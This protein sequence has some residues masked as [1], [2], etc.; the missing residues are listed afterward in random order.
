MPYITGSTSALVWR[1]GTE[2]VSIDAHRAL[3]RKVQEYACGCGVVGTVARS[4]T[5]NGT[6]RDI[7][8][9]PDAPSETWTVTFTDATNFTVSGSVTGSVAGGTVGTNYISDGTALTAKIAFRITAGGTA[10]VAADT[11]TIPVTA[12]A[13]SGQAEQWVLD[14]WS[15]FTTAGDGFNAIDDQTTNGATGALIFHGQGSGTEAIYQG[16]APFENAG[17][18]IWNWVH[19]AYSGFSSSASWDSQVNPSPE[20]FTAFIN[21][22]F[23][24][25]II[26]NERRIIVI[27]TASSTMHSCYMGFIKPFASP[28][29]WPYPN[30]VF[31]EEDAAT[32]YQNTGTNFTHS[33]FNPT[34]ANAHIRMVDGTWRPAASGT[35][36]TANFAAWPKQSNGTP[37]NSSSIIDNM[38]V[39]PSA[40]RQ[41]LPVLLISTEVASPGTNVTGLMTFGAMDGP[42]WIIGS[43]LTPQ[44]IV[45][46]DG[47]DHLSVNGIFRLTTVDFWAMP[48]A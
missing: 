13:L 29:E 5:G 47:V 38:E 1:Q 9:G 17:S 32:S 33:I 24:Y 35:V 18:S 45:S 25:W 8:S 14:R 2:V 31:G 10:F 19:R 40:D 21:S 4:G 44:T 42:K 34:A 30:A 11:F 39:L 43:G 3:L 23:T 15:P 7:A 20:V 46:V 27:A 36:T 26:V 6:I 48:L 16:I 12:G 41:L 37:G 28:L 22:D